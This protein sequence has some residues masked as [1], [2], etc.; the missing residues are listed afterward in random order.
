MSKVN[1][2]EDIHRRFS[3]SH[4]GED[5][6]YTGITDTNIDFELQYPFPY[7][8]DKIY[9]EGESNKV[10]ISFSNIVFNNIIRLTD[11]D[12][13][14][15]FEDCHFYGEVDCTNTKFLNKIRFRNCHFHKEVKFINTTFNDLADFY[16]CHFYKKMI[17]YKTD[18]M[19]TAVFSEVEFHENVL[20]TYTLINKL[21]IFRG[22]IFIKGLDLSL[23][24]LSGNVSVF[25]IQLDDYEVL[26]EK[27]NKEGYEK[28]VSEI[29]DI[30]IK[31]KRET[32][33]ILRKTFEVNSDYIHSLDYKKLELHTYD[34]IL[35]QNINT[36]ENVWSSRFNKF[37]LTLNRKSNLY[38]TRFE[39]GIRFTFLIGLFFFY[40]S[41]INLNTIEFA[42]PCQWSYGLFEDFSINFLKFLNPV[43]SVDY[44]G[45]Q[46]SLLFY[47]FDYLGRIFV[48]YGIYQTVQA[49][50]KYK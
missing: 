38:G 30:P 10:N 31:N 28:S 6:Y 47:F 19:Q 21:I 2:L 24:I 11:T 35:D 44:L 32:F 27:L 41:Y 37:I 48:G 8:L 25:D 12:T 29:G 22:T 49:F 40:F 7:P 5:E 45:Q 42:A 43:H 34:K 16:T 26:S 9:P 17:F 50:R 23:S 1:S 15:N 14:L 36:G 39:Y 18:F 46:H 33:R 3:T 13:F 20:F 4:F